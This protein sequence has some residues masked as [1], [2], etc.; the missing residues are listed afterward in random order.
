M[1]SYVKHFHP[2]L[3]T[4]AAALLAGI[5][6][7]AATA[8]RLGTDGKPA[9]TRPINEPY[10]NTGNWMQRHNNLVALAKKGDI[11]LYLEGDSITDGWSST[12]KTVLNKE[13]GGWKTANFGIGGDNCQNIL[14]RIQNGELDD[15]KPKVIMLMIGTNNTRS[16]SGEEIAGAVGKIVGIMKDKQPQAKILLLAIFPRGADPSDVQRKK[17]EVAN[18]ILA[19]LDDGKNVKFMNINDKFLDP[20]GKLIGF[21]T[22]NL[23]PNAKGYQIWADAVKP[24]L[25]EW[26]GPPATATAA[27]TRAN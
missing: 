4:A 16:Y 27:A 23:H 13:F 12:G 10:T 11:D 2:L 15:C 26:L 9:D 5:L 1:E 22:D 6:L 7:G 25:I 3:L 20:Q 18:G 24:Q 14:Y 8:P 19:K 21:N 17:I